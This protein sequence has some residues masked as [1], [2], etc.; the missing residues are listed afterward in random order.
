MGVQSSERVRNLYDRRV[1]SNDCRHCQYHHRLGIK[2]LPAHLW[3]S[4]FHRWRQAEV[5]WDDRDLPTSIW[6][7]SFSMTVPTGQSWSQIGSVRTYFTLRYWGQH[8]NLQSAPN[9]LSYP[10]P[11]EDTFWA[12][13]RCSQ[14]LLSQVVFSVC[15]KNQICSSSILGLL[16]K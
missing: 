4:C 9:Q 1:K 5:V 10:R 15:F 7:L 13:S 16:F 14:S 12:H 8:Q 2:P 6:S 3:W 11:V